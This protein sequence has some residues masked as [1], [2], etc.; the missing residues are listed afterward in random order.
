MF[1]HTHGDRWDQV[2]WIKS[3]LGWTLRIVESGG[4]EDQKAG[5]DNV[6]QVVVSPFTKADSLF[7]GEQVAVTVDKV[8]AD[9]RHKVTVEAG[10]GEVDLVSQVNEGFRNHFFTRIDV[11]S[12]VGES[13]QDE[14]RQEEKLFDSQ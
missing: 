11:L 7:G 12:Q 14:R 13:L 8:L 6:L 1:V 10:P 3:F 4:V 5:E 9:G 2:G